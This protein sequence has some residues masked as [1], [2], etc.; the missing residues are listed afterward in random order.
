ML[1]NTNEMLLARAEI[2]RKQ[3]WK[4][5]SSEQVLEAAFLLVFLDSSHPET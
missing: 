3:I 4:F 1:L 5:E 2:V